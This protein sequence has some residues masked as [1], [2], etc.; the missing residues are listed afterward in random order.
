M[1]LL[2]IAPSI[3]YPP[4]FGGSIRIYHLLKSAALTHEVH[5]V[6]LDRIGK[7]TTELNKICKRVHTFKMDKGYR[8]AMKYSLL[9]GKS[10]IRTLYRNFSLNIWMKVNARAYD[11]IVVESTQMAWT[12]M[13]DEVP[14]ILDMHNLEYEVPHRLSFN[15]QTG[16]I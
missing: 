12:T 6:C 9:N 1:K 13:P 10:H 4:T 2:W 8:R 15:E 7:V 5:L 11:A 3:P 16:I 14:K